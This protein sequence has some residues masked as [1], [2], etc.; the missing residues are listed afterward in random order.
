VFI[1]NPRDAL[2]VA[3]AHA[4][5]LQ[6]Q[7]AAERL[8]TGSGMRHTVAESLRRMADRLDPGALASR[9]VHR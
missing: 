7:A 3:E 1:T 4:R 2:R 8:H 6:S 5:L 9:P